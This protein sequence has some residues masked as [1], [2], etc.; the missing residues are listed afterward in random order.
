M[1]I[2]PGENGEIEGDSMVV[3][4]LVLWDSMGKMTKKNGILLGISWDYDEL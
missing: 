4:W 3:L 1:I 2:F